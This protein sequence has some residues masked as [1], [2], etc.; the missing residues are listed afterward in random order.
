[1]Q[2][3]EITTE[4]ITEKAWDAQD[5]GGRHLDELQGTGKRPGANKRR[6]DEAEFRSR[7]DPDPLPPV[8]AQLCA[9]SIGTGFM[10]MF[11]PD[12]IPHLIELYL[13]NRQVPE[14]GHIDLVGFLRGSPEP[15]QDG[16]LR[17]PHEQYTV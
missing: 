15:L 16:F 17:P 8:L 9:L 3:R 2:G 7:T 1:D 12:E 4:P 5:P 14:Q 11:T 10:G 13:R 6:Q